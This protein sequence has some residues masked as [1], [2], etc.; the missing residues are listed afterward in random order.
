M[1]KILIIYPILQNILY[2]KKKITQYV[3]VK[4]DFYSPLP[5]YPADCRSAAKIPPSGAA[6]MKGE[7]NAP[8]LI[9][10]KAGYFHYIISMLEW[11]R[12]NFA[13]IPCSLLERSEDPV[14]RGCGELHY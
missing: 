13:L 10:A 6:G 5:E 3:A 12:R 7:V 11:L 9:R 8:K 14:L 4:S 2:V 1:K